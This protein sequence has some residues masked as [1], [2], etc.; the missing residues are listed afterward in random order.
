MSKRIHILLVANSVPLKESDFL[1]DKFFG[2]NQRFKVDFACWDSNEK[3]A[4]FYSQ[5]K[6]DLSD[7]KVYLIYDKWSTATFI[8]L[9]FI[10]LS[11]FIFSPAVSF[12]LA[13][14][15]AK[16]YGRDFKMLFL[17]FTTY[18]PII[19]CKPDIIHF[20]FGTLAKT[21]ADIKDYTK[22][23]I[24]VSFRGYDIN[25]VGLDNATYY[26]QVWHNVDGVHFL[27][28]DLKTRA[29]A[30][31]Y[32]KNSVE[33][34]IPPGVDAGF[35][36]PNNTE[37]RTEKYT[38]LS[39][40][41]IVWKKGYDTALLAIKDLVEKG[42]DIEYRIVGS[43]SSI[44]QILFMIYELE[45]ETNV[46]LLGDISKAEIKKELDRADVFL[47]T[48]ISEGFC[49]AVVEAQ[50]M[51]V[52]IVATDADG[53]KE[54]VVDNVTGFVVP[55]WSPEEIAAKIEWCYVN[56]EE[57]KEMGVQGRQRVLDNFTIDMQINKFEA[58]Y[59]AVYGS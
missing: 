39:V 22:A 18:Y 28:S 25:Y 4:R 13:L 20:E 21:F 48:S 16:R 36:K 27:G 45:L 43:G 40:G 3:K 19:K 54:N 5:Y 24:S 7:S 46:T 31:G 29:V 1:R 56:K 33:S 17:K 15:L 35:F 44:Q 2:L 8:K 49:N 38:V 12:K 41:R 26:E 51:A 59:K 11:R 53:L 52:P 47:Q 10:N 55:K 34:F 58:F 37:K 57:A 42:I 9:L 23:K 14:G 50:S 30:R 32:K 6:R